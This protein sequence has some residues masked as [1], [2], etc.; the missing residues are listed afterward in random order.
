MEYELAC[1]AKCL[2]EQI[3]FCEKQIILLKSDD[4]DKEVI[5]T[6]ESRLGGFKNELKKL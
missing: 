2:V 3:H 6:W 5:K 4:G 1:Q